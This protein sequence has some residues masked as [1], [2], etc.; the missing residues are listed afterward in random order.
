MT[1]CHLL[2]K[3]LVMKICFAASPLIIVAIGVVAF[4][5]ISNF[6]FSAA[7][8]QETLEEQIEDQLEDEAEENIENEVEDSVEEDVE[9]EVE[10]SVETEVEDDI[11]DS[12]EN[13]V[14]GNV[15]DEVE[16]EVEDDVEDTVE[17]EVEDSVEDDVE[18]EVEDDVEDGVEDSVEDDVEDEVED[19]VENDVE[20]DTE[21]DVEDGV[22]EDAEEDAEDEIED[23]SASRMENENGVEE[24]QDDEANEEQ[25]ESSQNLPSPSTN[26]GAAEPVT[27]VEEFFEI[28][29]DDNENAFARREWLLLASAESI[30]A[31][32]KQ[33]YITKEI[34]ALDGLDLVLLRIAAPANTDIKD[35]EA[36]IRNAAPDAEI[37]R[38]HIYRPSAALMKNDL[39]GATPSDLMP[40]QENIQGDG[41]VIGVID[42]QVDTTHNALTHTNITTRNFTPYKN[43]QPEAHG[44]SVVS[45]LAGVDE[46]Y[47]GLLPNAKIY[48]ASVFFRTADGTAAGT[49]AGLV[50]ALD[51]MAANNVPVVNMSLSGPP[52]I[53]LKSAIER[54]YAHGVVVVAAAG[55]DG[56][57]APPSYPAGYANV[58]AVTAVSSTKTIYR[59]ANHGAYIDFAAP[60]VDIKHASIRNEYATSSGTSMAAPFATAVLSISSGAN[61]NDAAPEWNAELIEKLQESAEDLGSPGFDP[62]Y[63]YGLIRLPPDNKAPR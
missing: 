4:N 34:D 43:L 3:A 2:S 7:A 50:K 15:E 36:A 18:D 23:D 17:S 58:I 31:L 16:D 8:A 24:N 45:I 47:H 38:N 48:T 60:G 27:E 61:G 35:A 30:T 52:N 21:G 57:A 59:L 37:D 32:S 63:G 54:A 9:D 33:G 56:P 40:L 5:P 49:T 13:E 51:W 6:G 25:I 42:T 1:S 53:I 29:F 26:S 11:E 44:T 10:D 22:E 55:N 62:I 41:L 28:E 20:D 19:E 39:E 14:E 12:V 46:G